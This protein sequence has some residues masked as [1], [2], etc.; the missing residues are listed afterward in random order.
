MLGSR[1]DARDVAQEA[2]ARAYANWRRAST[3]PEAWVSRV[4][5][6]L[7]IDLL[8]RRGRHEP[9][10]AQSS[11]DPAP[12]VAERIELVKALADLPRR[13]RQVVVMRYLADLPESE[14]AAQLG[15]SPGT[16]KQHASR[17]LSALRAALSQPV[18]LPS[19]APA[20]PGLEER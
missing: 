13:Q 14:V 10:A 7:A 15:C 2:M 1:E 17:G 18:L 12:S 3:C 4:A 11:A 16:V 20:T 8:R 19:P 6:N 5:A 9:V